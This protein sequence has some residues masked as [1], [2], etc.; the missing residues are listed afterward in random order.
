MPNIAALYN[1]PLYT[2]DT[3]GF[4]IIANDQNETTTYKVH[5]E[6]IFS[7]FTYRND[8][9]ASLIW[10][11]NHNLNSDFPLVTCWSSDRKIVIPSDVI[12]IDNNNIE[13][14]FPLPVAGTISVGKV[15]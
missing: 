11:V 10:S 8:Y 15:S 14:H 1:Y 7:E 3:T 6:T 4:H 5:T 12:S 2:G 9:T 13:V